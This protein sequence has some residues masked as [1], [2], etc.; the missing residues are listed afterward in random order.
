MLL[1]IYRDDIIN[2]HTHVIAVF[3]YSAVLACEIRSQATSS[4]QPIEDRTSFT[5][6]C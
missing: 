5:V 3:L 2:L 1:D 6:Q 4:K